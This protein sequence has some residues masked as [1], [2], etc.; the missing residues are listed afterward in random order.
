MGTTYASFGVPRTKWVLY[1]C[2]LEFQGLNGYCIFVVWGLKTKWLLFMHPFGVLG[3]EWL[4][5]ICPWNSKGQEM[6]SILPKKTPINKN[7]GWEPI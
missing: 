6:L 1:M 3:I 7:Q 2:P 5:Y 4:L